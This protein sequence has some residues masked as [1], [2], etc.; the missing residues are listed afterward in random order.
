MPPQK[1]SKNGPISVAALEQAIGRREFSPV[2]LL[3]GEEDFLLEQTLKHFIDA[4]VDEPLR[5][6][7]LDVVY[8]SEVDAKQVAALAAS[9]P[10]MGDRRVVVVREFDKLP[11]KDPLLSYLQ[12]PSPTTSL[13]LFSSKPDFRLKFYKTLRESSVAV[14]SRPLY[15][16][17][18][19]Q[20]IGK[21]VEQRGKQISLQAC[22]MMQ[23]YVGRSLR[24][25]HNEIEK[26]FIYVGPKPEIGLDDI[27]MVVGMSRQYNVYELQNAV[28]A[29]DPA[30]AL[31]IAERMLDSGEQ[32][33]GMVIMLTRYTQK[34]WIIRDSLARKKQKA[35]IA[36]LLKISPKQMFW[37]DA[38][39]Q[40]ARNFTLRDLE[41]GFLLLR[42]ADERLKTSN[43]DAKLV[44]TLLLYRLIKG[45]TAEVE[46]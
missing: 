31:E 33:T 20:W 24:E 32:P 40:N 41:R 34:L 36:A 12:H 6:F 3:Y 43:G 46:A 16:S 10:M 39:M 21:N 45:D 19:P 23:N 26:L 30:R 27:N 25:I 38:D 42:E 4:S 13:L 1:Q 5:G 7:N 18:I 2:Y 17:E 15:E 35:E 8:G 37:L 11:N 14:E 9:F 28:G 22:Q 44:M 29:K